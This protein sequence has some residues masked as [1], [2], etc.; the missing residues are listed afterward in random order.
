[1]QIQQPILNIKMVPAG[2]ELVLAALNK[3]PRETSDPLFQEIV[4]QCSQQMQELQQAAQAAQ[5]AQATQPQGATEKAASAQPEVA[6]GG[7]D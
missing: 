5:A 7:T 2:V 6:V 3:L 1:M 4:G